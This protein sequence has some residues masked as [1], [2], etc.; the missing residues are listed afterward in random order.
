MKFEKGGRVKFERK[1][2][3][4]ARAKQSEIRNEV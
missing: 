2:K 1:E 4:R 3:K